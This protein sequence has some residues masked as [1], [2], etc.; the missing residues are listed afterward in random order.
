[1]AAELLGQEVR[2]RRLGA[3]VLALILAAFGVLALTIADA[4]GDLIE[5]ITVSFPEVLSTFIGAD[6][7]GGYVVGE[8]F[9]LI[10][11]ITV[12]TFAVV[13]GAAALAGEE[14]EGT[15]AVLVAQPVT[16][17]RLLLVKAL[18]VLLALTAVVAAN[19]VV[20]A[21]FIAADATGLTLVGLTGG[22]AHLLFLGLAFGAIAFGAA[23]ATG[24]PTI[25]AGIAGA[26]ALVSYLSATMLPVAGLEGWARLSPWY[27][28]VLSSDPLHTGVDAADLAVFAS[29]V[30]AAMVV[31]VPTFRH[32]DLRG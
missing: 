24:R 27:Y 29:I 22:S 19:W 4:L 6:A 31:A 26:V 16:R 1:M 28:Y 12:V 30:L 17:T 8:M 23:A 13:I 5:T 18:G 32:R 3:G 10:F 2:R 25:G 15:M 11:P 9:S 20:M 21:T 7:P 14:R